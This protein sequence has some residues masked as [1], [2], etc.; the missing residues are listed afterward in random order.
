MVEV[1]NKIEFDKFL[2]SATFIKG[3]YDQLVVG[4]NGKYWA[5]K[6]HKEEY[7]KRPISSF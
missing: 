1:I 4:K 3:F 7:I 6:K 2:K 5:L